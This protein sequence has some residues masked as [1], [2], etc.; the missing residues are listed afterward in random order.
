LVLSTTTSGI[1]Q[2]NGASEIELNTLL[3]DVNSTGAVN[4]DA[5]TASQVVV[6]GATAD[7]TLG[8]RGATVTLNES[9]Q[10]SLDTNFTATSLVGA[11]NELKTTNLGTT[12]PGWLA[13]EVIS[14][15]DVVYLDWDAG[16]ARTGVYLA[17]NTTS[18]KQDPVGVALTG[19]GA[20][21]TIYIATQ[22][23]EAVVNTLITANQEG[24][25]VYLDTAGGVTLT[26]PPNVPGSGD[27]SQIVGQVSLAGAAGVAKIIV[28]LRDPK[29]M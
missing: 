4:I 2:L 20:G 28:Q 14:I 21:T 8:A 1:L 18:G 6:S 10:T 17:D 19:G 7:L 29:I 3:V 24:S 13:S 12:T 16:N 11:V 25:P 15:G 23:Q 9:G 5:V 26:P 22:G 27:S